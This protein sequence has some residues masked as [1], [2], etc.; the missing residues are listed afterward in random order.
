MNGYESIPVKK[1][2]KK[3]LADIG[4]K[5]ETYDILLNRVL[6]DYFKYQK[7]KKWKIGE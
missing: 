7:D 6:D 2:T 5:G 4:T 3:R 1:N